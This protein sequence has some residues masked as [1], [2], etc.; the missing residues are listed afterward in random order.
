MQSEFRFGSYS[1]VNSISCKFRIQAEGGIFR[2]TQ[3][4]W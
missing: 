4:L 2:L 1:E 3:F